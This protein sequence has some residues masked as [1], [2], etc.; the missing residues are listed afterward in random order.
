MTKP[1][2]PELIARILEQQEKN[3]Q[4]YIE[5]LKTLFDPEH[6]LTIGSEHKPT[7]GSR[8]SNFFKK[9]KKEP[10]LT[11]EELKTLKLRIYL[12]VGP[13]SWDWHEDPI[14]CLKQLG[15][16]PNDYEFWDLYIKTRDMYVGQKGKNNES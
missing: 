12:S 3:H 6:K 15:E 13:N 1:V 7:I 4:K 5:S 10:E 2:T 8:I 16:N 11:Y 14:T 9:S